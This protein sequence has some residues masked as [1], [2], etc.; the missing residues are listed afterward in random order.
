L[1]LFCGAGGCS[2]GY[3]R[4]GFDVVGVDIKTQ[5][6]YPFEFVRGDALMV[7]GDVLKGWTS[8]DAI[9]ASPPCQGY[10]VANNI[11]GRDDHP[12][13]IA[14]VRELLIA[15]GLPYVIENVEGAKAEMRNPVTICGLS[16][17]LNVRRHRLFECNFPVM[18]YP[19][20]RHDGDWLL[21]FGHSVLERG[22]VVGKAKGGGNTIK[23][24]HT[25]TARGREAMGIDWMNRDELSE[26]IPPAYTEHIGHYLM[27]EIN[28]KAE[29]A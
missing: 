11:H 17:G 23:R 8:F 7:L 10:S 18:T 5:P 4:A 14:E 29:A 1:D 26:A 12:M 22:T 13:L 20:G 21:V 15:T 9:H 24:I 27:A 25:T 6:N 2:E 28:A 3:R 16:L 19:C